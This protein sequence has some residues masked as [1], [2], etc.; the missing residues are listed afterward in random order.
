MT[1]QQTSRPKCAIVP[2]DAAAPQPGVDR[3]GRA[4]QAT[5]NAYRLV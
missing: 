1:N 3:H 5:V 4:M 2:V